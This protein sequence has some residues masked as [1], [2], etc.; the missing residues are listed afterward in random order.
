MSSKKFARTYKK[1]LHEYLSRLDDNRH[2]GAPLVNLILNL[3]AIHI[4]DG[5]TCGRHMSRAAAS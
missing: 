5:I 1:A 4:I 2:R 3:I